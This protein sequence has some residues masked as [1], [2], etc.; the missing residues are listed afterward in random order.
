MA[1]LEVYGKLPFY[2]DYIAVLSTPESAAWKSWLLGFAGREGIRL[3]PGRWWFLF[4]QARK[5]ALIAGIIEHSSDGI[6]EFP[7]SLF[8]SLAGIKTGLLP[9]AA[10]ITWRVLLKERQALDGLTSIEQCYQ[11][12]RGRQILIEPPKGDKIPKLADALADAGDENRPLFLVCPDQSGLMQPV[13]FHGS[14]ALF[15]EKWSALSE[16]G[17]AS[18]L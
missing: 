7:F 5:S 3:P 15:M 9:A 13:V 4:R 1:A 11:Q 14:E 17:I 10:L 8:I 12:M 18:A 6:R 16:K 2:Q